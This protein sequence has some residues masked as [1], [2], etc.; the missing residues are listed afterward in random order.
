MTGTPAQPERLSPLVQRLRAPNPG[1][2]TLTGTNSYIVGAGPDFLVIDP[3]P[4]IPAHIEALAGAA[5]GA[6][7]RITT[8][9]VTHGH[10]DHFPG[11]ER[12][13]QLTGAP[14]AA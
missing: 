14:I 9:L 6:G 3:G 10:P 2:M 11:A 8:I 4:D 1:P 5:T 12:L 7:G 13:R